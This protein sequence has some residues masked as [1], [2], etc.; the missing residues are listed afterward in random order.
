[1]A[2]LRQDWPSGLHLSA[3]RG[4]QIPGRPGEGWHCVD[5]GRQGL[6]CEGDLPLQKAS[7]LC[8]ALSCA[9][10]PRNVLS[11]PHCALAPVQARF[12]S[13]PKSL[14]F[15]PASSWLRQLAEAEP[16]TELVSFLSTSLL[17]K[18]PGLGAG[19]VLL[20]SLCLTEAASPGWMLSVFLSVIAML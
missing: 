5:A 9:P 1:M 10:A 19:P 6:F 2:V 12:W 7:H 20:L 13:S 14:P 8:P 16:Q 4:P 18:E 17:S 3:Q 15:L 11:A